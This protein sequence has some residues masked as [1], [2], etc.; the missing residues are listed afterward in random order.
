MDRRKAFDVV[1]H[2]GLMYTLISE[3]DIDV[4][5]LLAF[6]ALYTNMTSFVNY[7]GKCS[8]WF[9]VKQRTRQGDITTP[10]LY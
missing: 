10:T 2:G 5:T 6:K 4:I 8:D 9:P 1:W 7:M 3:T